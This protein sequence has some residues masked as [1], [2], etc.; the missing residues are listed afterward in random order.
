MLLDN[1]L[2]YAG[3]TFERVNPYEKDDSDEEIFLR[4]M[5]LREYLRKLRMSMIRVGNSKEAKA[6]AKKSAKKGDD[7]EEKKE[8]DTADET[9]DMSSTSAASKLATSK[10]DSSAT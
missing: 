7:E 9:A 3:C 1:S 5:G 6:K 4:R 8:E 10:P 2:V